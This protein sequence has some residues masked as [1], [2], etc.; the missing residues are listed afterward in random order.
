MHNQ[1]QVQVQYLGQEKN[2]LL[3]I[4]QF[5]TAP[6]Q[7]IAEACNE[8]GFSAQASDFYPGLRKPVDPI[9][10]QQSLALV[11]PL[12]KQHFL[13]A[14]PLRAELSLCA[15]SLTT[16][17]ADKLR[18]IQAVPHIDTPDPLQFAM[19]H[20]LCSENFGGTSFY[21]H[22]SSG[23]ETITEPHMA[24]YFKTVKQELMAQNRRE[25][26]YINGDTELFQRIGQVPVKFNRC[27]IYRSNLLHSGDINP[28]LGLSANPREG[29]L[30]INSFFRFR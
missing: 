27:I 24:D 14:E 7:L 19:V 13:I 4:D 18:P 28:T 8:P 23:Y 29:R 3:V 2:P 10:A 11:A 5:A 30:T 12:V 16:T 9:Y 15:F 17:P 26:D 22:R 6:E 20:Y 21:R 1:W 25:F